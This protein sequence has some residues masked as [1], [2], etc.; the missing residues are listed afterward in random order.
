M[1]RSAASSNAYLD[2]LVVRAA[3]VVVLYVNST[4]DLASAEGN[5]AADGIVGRYAYGYAISWHHLDSK[6]TH[7]AAQLCKHLVA[8]VTLDAIQTAAVDRHDRALHVNEIIL[9]QL[10][11]FPIKDCAIA[12]DALANSS[13][14]SAYR[15]FNLT[16]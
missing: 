6:A 9:A 15:R 3:S 1:P 12:T 14:G 11:S 5:D 10:L 16:S 2:A 4:R 8:L 13:V 7:T